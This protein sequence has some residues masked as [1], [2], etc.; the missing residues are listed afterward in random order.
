MYNA[1]VSTRTSST[2]VPLHASRSSTSP[3]FL[4]PSGEAKYIIHLSRT[5]G[6]WIE[7]LICSVHCPSHHHGRTLNKTLS[8]DCRN[9]NT[10]LH[11]PPTF[12]YLEDGDQQSI[13]NRRNDGT[14]ERGIPS[15][16]TKTDKS[17]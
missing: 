6:F 15:D 13:S 2:A 16:I 10:A 11:Q 5:K 4:L 14:G 1:D 3:L 8:V 9:N 17:W 12:T 7:S